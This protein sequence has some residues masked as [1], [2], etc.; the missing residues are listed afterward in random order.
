MAGHK[1]WR[2]KNVTTRIEDYS[3]NACEIRF[4]NTENILSN[5]PTKANGGVN[6]GTSV[7][8][9]AFDGNI[10][11]LVHSVWGSEKTGNGKDWFIQYAFNTP[12]TVTQIQLQMRQDMQP[13][14]GHEWQTADVECS[15]DGT[16]W[17][18]Y[19]KIEPKI[20]QMDLSL[21]TVN[22]I[23][24]TK[25]AGKSLQDNAKPSRFVLIHDWKTGDFIQKIVPLPDGTWT[26]TQL[27]N[28][29]VLVTHVGED[30]YK[31]QADGGVVP[32]SVA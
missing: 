2:L 26:Y 29:P 10:S 32:V 30:S 20:A 5:D 9:N 13:N 31:P 27:G 22:I 16:T 24:Y 21:K 8:G 6:D 14:W 23:P 7:A 25:V 12:V 3:R 28:A 1:Y 19:G 15:D 4:V 17:T 11:T 18:L